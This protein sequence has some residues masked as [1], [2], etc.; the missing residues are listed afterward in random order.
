MTHGAFRDLFYSIFP[1]GK[2]YL[3]YSR[4]E[5]N[6]ILS[7][8]HGGG[9][10]PINIPRRRYG[11]RGRD[12]YTRRLIQ[13]IIELSPN[14]PFYIYSDIHREK[15]DLNRDIKEAAQ[16]NKAMENVWHNWN[17][18]LDSYCLAVRNRY[19][20]GLYIDLHSHDNNG[21]FQIGYGL[22]VKDYLNLMKDLKVKTKHSTMF[23]LKP[24]DRIQYQS[25]HETLFGDSSIPHTLKKMGY[26]VLVPESDTNY[27]NGG[28]NIREFSG[29]GIGALQIEAPISVLRDDLDGVAM[30]IVESIGSFKERF[31]K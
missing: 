13:K 25:E 18:I 12:S 23:P 8:P 5:T 6:V 29:D 1:E 30:A 26:E 28:R 19:M 2:K 22:S 11:N 10:K 4:G 16:G 15:I 9:I 24:F 7:A 21:K 31:M 20:R 27:L 14:K 3:T 17:R